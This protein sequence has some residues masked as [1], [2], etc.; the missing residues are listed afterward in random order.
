MDSSGTLQTLYTATVEQNDGAYQI[1][2]P[3]REITNGTLAEDGTYRIALI[4]TAVSGTDTAVPDSTH[5]VAHDEQQ[6]DDDGP[7]V[8]EGE[9]R[10]VEIEHLGDQGDGIA[11]VEH[12][13][14]VI[15]PDT[16]VGD[17]ATVE[18]QQVREN[19]AFAEVVDR[20]PRSAL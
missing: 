7:P 20:H 4:S 5:S 15:V 9:H 17:R 19:V 3:E 8:T 10:D 18:I 13:Y 14:V 2:I 12:G 11:K 1:T 16:T 6:E